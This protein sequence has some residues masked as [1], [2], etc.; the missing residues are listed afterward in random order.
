MHVASTPHKTTKLP[1][2]LMLAQELIFVKQKRFKATKPINALN[3]YSAQEVPVCFF[4]V[5]MSTH[6]NADEEAARSDWLELEV[7]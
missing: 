4:C 6:K 5:N 1:N 3:V 7:M 2:V